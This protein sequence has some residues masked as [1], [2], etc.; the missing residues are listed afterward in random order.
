MWYKLS[1]MVKVWLSKP[2]I[3]ILNL[4]NESPNRQITRSSLKHDH[5]A[6]INLLIS[7]SVVW[8]KKINEDVIYGK[9]RK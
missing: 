2:E 4:I 1:Q 6:G 3:E 7:K 8:R 9:K 5:Y